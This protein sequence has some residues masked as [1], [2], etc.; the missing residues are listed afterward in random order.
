VELHINDGDTLTASGDVTINGTGDLHIDD[1]ATFSGGTTQDHDIGGDVRIDAG[2]T[3]TAPSTEDNGTLRVGGSWTNT[4]TGVFTSGSG[5]IIFTAT[6]GTESINA[7]GDGF[8]DLTLGETSGSAQWDLA[9]AIDI[10][11]DLLID[12]GTLN[13]AGAYNVNTAGAVQINANGNYSKNTGTW[14]FDGTGS[15]NYTDNRG[16]KAN[17]GTVSIDATSSTRTVS[18][19]TAMAVMNLSVA[20]DG[21]LTMG[22][23][24]LTVGTASDASSGDINVTSGGSTSQSS[25]TVTVLS[26]SGTTQWNGSGT[27]TAS[28][29]TI[30]SGATTFTIDNDTGDL[31]LNLASTF[32]IN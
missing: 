7:Q 1:N 26:A 23:N 32:T 28:N 25:G 18:M 8:Y 3:L 29:L 16:T 9:S 15:F 6:S 21:V 31:P 30:G 4:A 5:K 27:F 11:G 22:S 17:L 2:A 10:N 13:Q 24:D 12:Y 14:M 19:Q 20:A